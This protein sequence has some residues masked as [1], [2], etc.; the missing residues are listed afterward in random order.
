MIRSGRTTAHLDDCSPMEGDG[1]ICPRCPSCF[2]LPNT[3][4]HRPGA[5]PDMPHGLKSE[6]MCEKYYV[7]GHY[8]RRLSDSEETDE[9]W[10]A[11]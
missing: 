4:D 8:W 1:C 11:R 10:A 5:Y 6:G 9:A 2:G 7:G 3:Y